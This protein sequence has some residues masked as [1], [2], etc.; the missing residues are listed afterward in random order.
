ML[1]WFLVHRKIFV[2]VTREANVWFGL[3]IWFALGVGLV[4]QWW[5]FILLVLFEVEDLNEFVEKEKDWSI[6]LDLCLSVG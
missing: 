2:L 5:R 6:M 3:W 1:L 4:L